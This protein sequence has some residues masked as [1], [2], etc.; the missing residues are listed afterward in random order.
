[1]T[2]RHARGTHRRHPALATGSRIM[3]AMSG[4]FM[5]G[6]VLDGK[7]ILLAVIGGGRFG[8]VY[9]ALHI[10]LQKP[11][12]VKVLHGGDWLVSRDF[13]QF[14]VEAEALGRLS[15]P[16]I[17]G[18]TDFGVDPRGAGTPYLVME[19][20][21][22]ATLEQ[23][24]AREGRVDLARIAPWVGQIALALDHAHAGGVA[25][26]DL[27]SGNVVL[28]ES[29]ASTVAKVI[30]FGQARLVH[31]EPSP[32]TPDDDPPELRGLGRHFAGT[33]DY[34]APERL[35]GEP[36]SPSADVYALAA[37]T[38]RLM[39][40]R[41]PFEGDR[42]AVFNAQLTRV[43]PAPSTV[44]AGI[45]A[46]VDAALT[47]GLAKRAADRAATAGEFADLLMAAARQLVRTRWRLREAPR[48]IAVAVGL[49]AALAG[50][51][52]WLATFDL[53]QRLEGGTMDVRFALGPS[54]APDPRLLLVSIDD[55]SVGGDATPLAS[56][57][58]EF[59]A[60][61]DAALGDGAA[62]V[63]LDLLLPETWAL[64]R[65]FGDL[66]LQRADRLV[67]GL[68]SDGTSVVGPEAI[69]PLV[70]GA[71]GP[72]AASRL[73]GLVTHA[74]APDGVV[75]RART[76]VVDRD[77][78]ARYTLAGRVFDLA[79][80][81][82]APSWGDR[83]FLVDYTVDSAQLD[84]IGWRSFAQAATDGDARFEQ[85]ILLVGAE[86]TGSGDRHRVP[87][88]GRLSAEVSGLALQGII[89]NTLLQQRPL[90]DLPAVWVWPVVG[91][92]LFATGFP[93]LWMGRLRV[94]CGVAALGTRRRGRG[95]ALRIPGGT[96][97][98][99]GGSRNTV[100]DNG[101]CGACR[102]DPAA[103]T[104]RVELPPRKPGF[105]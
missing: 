56:R 27:S 14:R 20:V 69:D 25:H 88:P 103:R 58:D 73:F 75:R 84:R 92:L 76:A 60:A 28:V 98:S 24:A 100:P 26:G 33:P 22:G 52:P 29:G 4:E 34:T 72:E 67:L 101:G 71:L 15:H 6:G 59:A 17:V 82:T 13:E 95:R 57:G 38:Y 96:H 10:A 48:R 66:V 80:T 43:A 45:P 37:L 40:G 36:P 42:R 16:H 55:D 47:R 78:R 104:A 8:T 46:A 94:A 50:A 85:R 90:R 91:M 54:H 99:R 11:V 49:S 5:P 32:P 21:E 62:V 2:V 86:F 83:P 51:G 65:S 87:G 19:L 35:R 53:V 93:V 70:A 31:L 12:A 79:A 74:P 68:A 89:V 41:P 105:T 18:V 9:R 102:Q 63:A 44:V 39:T 64:A 30:D 97:G 61:L 23:L 77:G 7:Y 3:T 1:M 81:R